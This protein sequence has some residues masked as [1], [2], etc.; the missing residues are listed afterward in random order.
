MVLVLIV[1]HVAQFL[2][3]FLYF[4]FRISTFFFTN[5]SRMN[6]IYGTAFIVIE[7]LIR[8]M[9]HDSRIIMN[10][11]EIR[12]RSCKAGSCSE[13]QCYIL[14]RV[15][16]F[17]QLRINCGFYKKHLRIG[18]SLLETTTDGLVTE[19]K[20]L[21]RSSLLAQIGSKGCGNFNDDVLE[22]SYDMDHSMWT[23]IRLESISAEMYKDIK[24]RSVFQRSHNDLDEV[25]RSLISNL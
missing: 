2:E 8:N 20:Y 7:N 21:M 11:P 1:T 6:S 14:I 22:R 5:Y 18:W 24:N 17:D 15:L 16:L 25:V 3:R 9:W 19:C 23:S 10:T 12:C 4:I 13:D